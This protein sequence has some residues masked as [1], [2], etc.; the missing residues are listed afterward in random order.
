MPGLTGADDP[1]RDS[2]GVPV[3]PALRACLRMLAQRGARLVVRGAGA[4]VEAPRKGGDVAIAWLEAAHAPTL[5]AVGWLTDIGDGRCVLSP[6]GRAIVRLM[7]AA[8]SPAAA[9][10]GTTAPP[11]ATAPLPP[12][13]SPRHDADDPLA[14]LRARRTR[15]GG[16]YL[17]DEAFTAG[18]RL[19][20][21][22]HRAQMMPR[23]TANWQAVERTADESRGLAQGAR[24][25]G[26]GAVD[27][28]ERV[29]RA[30]RA[31]P[32]ELADLLID[33]CCHSLRLQ[34]VERR[35]NVPQ[36]SV[37]YLLGIALRGLARHYGLLPPVEA[38]WQPR[39][40]PRHWGSDDYRPTI[41]G[42]SP[43]PEHGDAGA[44]K[45]PP[46][47]LPGSA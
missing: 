15:T 17:T 43:P 41:D 46:G 1:A 2:D 34:D 18:E 40:R 28:G 37:H 23:V 3:D 27:A 14:W 20:E 38:A 13:A 12:L 8:P 10:A 5:T 26:G 35:R 42:G 24:E 21:D 16:P 29:R 47:H 7:K 33:V 45:V 4:V 36:R 22:F 6:A 11:P 30:L 19:R 32:P 39:P 44:P 25:R 31:V 9:G